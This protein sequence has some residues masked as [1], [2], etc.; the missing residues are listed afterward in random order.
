MKPDQDAGYRGIRR[1][2]DWNRQVEVLISIVST[3]R[4]RG[5]KQGVRLKL[6]SRARVGTFNHRHRCTTV[7]H[8]LPFSPPNFQ[9]LFRDPIAPS[10]AI[11][12]IQVR[13]YARL[14]SNPFSHILFGE[15]APY[16]DGP[17]F[18]ALFGA[19]SKRVDGTCAGFSAKDP[20]SLGIT[21]GSLPHQVVFLRASF[22][23]HEAL[24]FT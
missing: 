18:A 7:A 21:C 2:S 17:P 12:Q 11:M 20:L 5:L 3:L 1:C 19:L 22:I 14:E 24:P 13:S 6:L 4:N 15:R 8:L 16:P 23:Y 10:K 9:K